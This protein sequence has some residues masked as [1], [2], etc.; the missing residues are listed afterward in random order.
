MAH[1][2]VACL[3]VAE[4]MRL[5]GVF[6]KRDVLDKVALQFQEIKDRPVSGV[7]TSQPEFVYE[8]D[9]VAAGPPAGRYE[10]SR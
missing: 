2:E 7:M 9:P 10:V 3:V 5:V 6:T 4:N 8:T 1:L